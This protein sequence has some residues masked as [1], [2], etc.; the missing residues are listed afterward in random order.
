VTILGKA[1]S[2]LN[3]VPRHTKISTAY[4]S[5]TPQRSTGEWRCNSTHS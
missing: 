1:V 5:T 3:K 4:L 2:V